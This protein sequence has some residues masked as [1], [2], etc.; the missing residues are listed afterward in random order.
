MDMV[1]RQTGKKNRD[2]LSY[3]PSKFGSSVSNGVRV[4]SGQTY[5]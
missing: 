2:G 4:L 5:K 1:K 3:H